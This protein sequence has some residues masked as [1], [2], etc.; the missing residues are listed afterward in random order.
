MTHVS[1]VVDIAAW[2]DTKT[3]VKI[4]MGRTE[5]KALGLIKTKAAPIIETAR[6]QNIEALDAAARSLKEREFRSRSNRSPA[7]KA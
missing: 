1:P 7:V 2:A 4:R 3:A 6:S 5:S